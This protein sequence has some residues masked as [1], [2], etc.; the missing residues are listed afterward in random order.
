MNVAVLSNVSLRTK[1]WGGF[2]V[3]A[4]I[5]VMVGGKGLWN[6]TSINKAVENLISKDLSFLVK[7]KNLYALALTHRRYEKDFF[8][9]IGDPKK[10]QGYLEKFRNIS[11]KTRTSIEQIEA[12]AS[13]D[14]RF[15]GELKKAIQLSRTSYL[16]Y[17]SGFIAL[18][19]K[20]LTDP[21]LTPPEAN[22]MMGPIKESIYQFEESVTLLS[23]DA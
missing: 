18:S 20:I 4:L 5:V 3:M 19:E 17:A 15:S 16:D 11:D 12:L 14:A 2:L 9:N 8:L 7:A 21:N 6:I 22:K 13:K 1:L 23:A 10:Q